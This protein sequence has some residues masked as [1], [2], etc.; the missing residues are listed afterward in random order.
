MTSTPRARIGL[1]VDSPKIALWQHMALSLAQDVAEVQVVIV[2]ENSTVHRRHIKNFAY[3]LLNLFSIRNRQSV[4]VPW[5]DI[6][7]D[8]CVVVPF[9]CTDVGAWQVINPGIA[10]ALEPHDL[11][12]V[13]RFGMNL[14]RNPE[15]LPAKFGLLS[16]HHGDPRAFRGRPAGFYELLNDAES[17]GTVVQEL[18]GSIDSGRIRAFGQFRLTRHSYRR[19][20][21]H[22]FAQSSSL[23]RSAIL[24]CRQ[25]KILELGPHGPLNRLPSNATVV[26]FSMI[27]LGRKLQRLLFGL[28]LRREWRIAWTTL[29]ENVEPHGHLVLKSF[30]QVRTPSGITFVAD[31]FL[32]NEMTFICEAMPKNSSQG[33]LM[34]NDKNNWSELEFSFRKDLG[35][36]SYPFVVEFNDKTYLLPEMAQCGP[37]TLW[38][39]NSAHQVIGIQ[40]LA[41]LANHRLIDPVLLL[42]EGRWWLFAGLQGSELDH[43]HLWSSTSLE[44]P[45]VSHPKNPVVVDPARARNAGGFVMFQGQIHRLSQNNCREYGDGIT[46]CRVTSLDQDSYEEEPDLTITVEGFRGPHTLNKRGEKAIF[47]Y[48]RIAPHPLAWLPRARG[49]L[50]Q[51]R[52]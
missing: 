12:L 16:F 29:T 38:E 8:N 34:I 51:N 42:W 13:V 46:V 33:I 10:E 18:S 36:V 7:A 37:Q 9:S 25:D 39:M 26:K 23:L 5:R 50:T 4:R 22:V 45:F 14:I 35:H 32:L 27:M 6:V 43:L 52:Y 49:F 44:G 11:D 41:D 30:D 3:F 47:D 2:C 40:P 1:L 21:E 48:Y 15:I 20:L 24:N 19:T 28:F 17:I 31:P